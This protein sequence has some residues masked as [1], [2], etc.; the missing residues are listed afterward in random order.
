MNEQ[1]PPAAIVEL[2]R[3]ESHLNDPKPDPGPFLGGLMPWQQALLKRIAVMGEDERLI[4]AMPRQHATPLAYKIV[5]SAQE[6]VVTKAERTSI[7]A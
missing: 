4:I 6:Q 1:L 5:L 2:Q 3:A 7:T